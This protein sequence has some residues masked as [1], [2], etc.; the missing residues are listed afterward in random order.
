MLWQKESNKKN[1]LYVDLFA[2]EDEEFLEFTYLMTK[3]DNTKPLA[4]KSAGASLARRKE[5]NVFFGKGE[6]HKAIEK[7]NHSLCLAPPNSELVGLAYGNRS[8][9]FVKLK[10]YN[11]CLVDIEL[12]KSNK[13]PDRLVHK[14]DDREVQCKEGIENGECNTIDIG[15]KLSY[16]PHETFPCLANVLNVAKDGRGNFKVTAREDIG[17]GKTI[18]VWKSFAV[19]SVMEH[20]SK[21]NICLKRNTNLVPCNVCTV[22]M[23]CHGS[24]ENN[25]LH[26]GGECSLQFSG[27]PDLDAGM[28]R[29]VR[30]ILMVMDMFP[31]ADELMD[32]VQH[33]IQ[34]QGS[35]DMATSLT[36]SQLRYRDFLNLP[37]SSTDF[38]SRTFLTS[39]YF[40]YNLALDVCKIETYFNTE[41]RLRFLMHLLSLHSKITEDNSN[42]SKRAFE[43]NGQV[44]SVCTHGVIGLRDRYFGVSCAPNVMHSE[45]DDQLVHITIRPVKKG[46]PLETSLSDY[47]LLESK[48]TRQQAFREQ[49]NSACECSRCHGVSATSAQQRQITS[50]P[51][52]GAVSSRQNVVDNI[53]ATNEKYVNF[54]NRHGHIA[55]CDA[56]GKVVDAYLHFLRDKMSGI[57][58]PSAEII[59]AAF[60]M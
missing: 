14:L 25:V 42:W 29:E 21:C 31:N 24:C 40:M 7:Y 54:L 20:H 33:T 27:V 19:Y 52:Y 8:S 57:Q 18:A 48:A 26:E 53:Q 30:I 49:F 12:A 56:L 44:K 9:C 45:L 22:A 15:M 28:K 16:D 17:V 47:L 34:R 5:G 50:D 51:D 41:K 2:S 58:E 37:F 43:I 38:K 11:E 36:A 59:Q 39:L 23:F 3:S 46:E 60:E 6:F 35:A 55:W 32:F 13:F 1:A 10:M 4:N